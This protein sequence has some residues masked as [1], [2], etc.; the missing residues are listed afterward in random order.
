MHETV[1]R[2]TTAVPML[3]VMVGLLMTLID[4]WRYDGWDVL[5]DPLGYALIFMA[6]GPLARDERRLKIARWIAFALVLVSVAT[7][8]ETREVLAEYGDTRYEAN[9]L[10]PAVMGADVLDLVMVWFLVG[11]ASE[12]AYRGRDFR[13][14]EHI[15]SYRGMYVAAAVLAM[16]C[17]AIFYLAAPH[18]DSAEAALFVR[19]YLGFPMK[20][21]VGLAAALIV[22]AL[23]HTAWLPYDD[24]PAASR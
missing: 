2:R 20:A 1:P 18:E 4:F 15:L 24:D 3:V 22:Q 14:G 12:L 5:P 9:R 21:F 10:W 7:L 11:G 6:L 13:L 23:W 19:Y 16:P 8:H 17:D